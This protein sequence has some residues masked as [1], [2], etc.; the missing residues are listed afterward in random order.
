[1]CKHGLENIFFLNV[2]I[3]KL[4]NLALSYCLV[5]NAA[6]NVLTFYHT[7][8]TIKCEYVNMCMLRMNEETALVVIRGSLKGRQCV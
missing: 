3:Y 1:M 7:I 2:I 6:I 5:F 4:I 8:V